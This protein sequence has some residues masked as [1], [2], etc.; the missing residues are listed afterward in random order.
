[1][2][3][4]SRFPA[5]IALAVL[6]IASG[7]LYLVREKPSSSLPTA[8]QT[9]GASAA[10]PGGK[11]V[12]APVDPIPERLLAEKK[13]PLVF[14]ANHP[15]AALRPYPFYKR[16]RVLSIDRQID[17]RPPPADRLDEA[18]RRFIFDLF[19]GVRLVG[20]VQRVERHTEN[21]AVY[22]GSL[23]QV[24]GGDFILAVNGRAIAASFT[25]PGRGVYQIRTVADGVIAAIE[26]DEKKIPGCV[27]TTLAASGR[28]DSPQAVARLRLRT[29]L[30]KS[31]TE[32]A[33]AARIEGDDYGG[34]DQQGGSKAGLTFQTVDVLVVNTV[35]ARNGAGG[36]AGMVALIDLA[37]ARANAAFINSEIGVR[38]RLVRS[39]EVPYV[40]A[41]ITND[42]AA[43]R[44]GT[45]GFST[46]A[47]LRNAS[48]ADLVA[49]ITEDGSGGIANLYNGNATEAF[50]ISGR[51]GSESIFVHEI[52]H[53]FG[54]RHDRENNSGGTP[55]QPYAFGWRFT[56]AD[57]TQLRSIMAYAPGVGVPYF[58]NPDVTYLGVPTGVPIGQVN[59]SHN[60][61]VIRNTVATV[62]NFR[63]PLGNT[64]PVITLNSPLYEDTFIAP[65][66][67]TLAATAS[68]DGGT[69]AQV[70][71]Y[72]L[73]SDGNFDFSNISSTQLAVDATA[74]YAHTENAVGAGFW[75]VAAV[76]QDNDGAFAIDTVSIS[77]LPNYVYRELPL[78]AGKSRVTPK[79]INES[80]IVVGFAHDGNEEATNT[81]AASWLNGAL[82]LLNPLAGD[83]GAQALA[84]SSTGAIYGS[85]VSSGGVK[86]AVRWQGGANATDI[87]TVAAGFNAEEAVGV[88]ELERVFLSRFNATSRRFNGS[89]S[90]TLPLN[91]QVAAASNTGRNATG[92]DYNFPAAA[93]RSLRWLDGTGTQL[94]PLTGYLSSWGQGINR[95][96]T[97]AGLSSP[98]AG[99]F[100]TTNSQPTVWLAGTSTAIDLG[101]FGA[102]GGAA[103]GVNDFNHVVGNASAAS[104]GGLPFLWLGGGSIIDINKLTLTKGGL[105]R[106]ARAIN[107]RGQI[108]GTG[109]RGSA[110]FLYLLD[111]VPGLRHDYWLARF[112][113][114]AEI[115]AGALTGDAV[116]ADGDRISNTLER[117]LGLNP[118]EPYAASLSNGELPRSAIRADGRLYYTFR[119]LREP[120]D[121]DYT[122]E[123]TTSLQANT[124]NANALEVFEVATLN[125]ELEEVTVRSISPL[126]SQES[127]FIRL[128]IDR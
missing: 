5:W 40:E 94:P 43:L 128:S 127:A 69:I 126:T 46:V 41:G 20:R 56:M 49:A 95:T 35:A 45:G 54:C 51:P 23:D 37:V 113:T 39:Q 63:S 48:G 3:F 78:P 123:L 115:Q 71:F 6:L 66:T 16:T 52:G 121:L 10:I 11:T 97:V 21:R 91:N 77:V 79:A 15:N 90:I 96:G 9:I 36:A 50:S 114:P 8:S 82:F 102:I 108:T 26:L 67:V 116:D 92:I 98:S 119:R 28:V 88:D 38:L 73:K 85:S 112:F 62:A 31:L 65:G 109:F 59:Q 7:F 93:W 99:G 107:N 55:I 84:I 18:A 110:Q 17:L 80:G 53:N 44:A 122:P 118:R 81:R 101:T 42:I 25:T 120:R 83:T 58:S 4:S 125:L 29:E 61:Q 30:M 57:G 34:T 64:P 14:A 100:S 12:R 87:S 111:P 86:R 1:M 105:L 22:Y 106:D 74:P 117:A 24:P 60:A 103:Y 75:T 19:P 68:D 124:W 2:K 33:A 104:L 70:R 27:P 89:A 32:N 13:V 72:R 76:A 47:A